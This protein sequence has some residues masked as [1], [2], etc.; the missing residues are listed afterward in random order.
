MLQIQINE[1][2]TLKL[3]YTYH[4][5]IYKIIRITIIINLKVET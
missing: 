3:L 2:D 5:D 4:A 1:R